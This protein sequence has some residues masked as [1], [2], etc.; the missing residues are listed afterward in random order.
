MAKP[1]FR[2]LWSDQAEADLLSIWRYGADEWSPATADEYLDDIQH[3][4]D[5]LLQAPELGKPRGELMYGVR[6]IPL[7]PHIIFYRVT[8]R[9]VEILRVL[10][11]REDIHEIFH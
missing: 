3:T 8:V 4:C 5:M 9:G 1:E 6:S 7:D 10:H 11:E 2:L